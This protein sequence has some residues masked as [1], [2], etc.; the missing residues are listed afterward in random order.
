MRPNVH[1]DTKLA[2][3]LCIGNLIYVSFFIFVYF[4]TCQNMLNKLWLFPTSNVDYCLFIMY[5]YSFIFLHISFKNVFLMFLTLFGFSYYKQIC[6]S[7]CYVDIRDS[8]L[9]LSVCPPTVF[10]C[11]RG[12][13]RNKH[14]T[15]DLPQ[16]TDSLGQA[17]LHLQLPPVCGVARRHQRQLRQGAALPG[18]QRWGDVLWQ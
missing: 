5:N 10:L 7:N 12:R 17:E 15:D 1:V 13:K 14:G 11:W 8:P 2:I 3:D 18:C 6:K 9:S 4:K 16:T